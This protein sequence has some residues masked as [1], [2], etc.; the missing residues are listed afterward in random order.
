MK[1]ITELTVELTDLYQ[2]LKDGTIDVKFASEMNNNRRQDY[3]MYRK[4]NLST[5]LCVMKHQ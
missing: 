4:C 2:A 1:N 3:Q 5:Q